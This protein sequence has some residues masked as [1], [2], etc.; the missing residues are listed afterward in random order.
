MLVIVAS[1]AF[2]PTFT[3][4]TVY[5]PSCSGSPAF[6]TKRRFRPGSSEA[7]Q[8]R[9]RALGS[10]RTPG[11]GLVRRRC[12]P[13]AWVR[14]NPQLRDQTYHFPAPIPSSESLCDCTLPCRISRSGG[15]AIPWAAPVALATTRE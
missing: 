14:P 12:R 6:T 10:D 5:E 3:N 13:C 15:A 11:H 7:K 2:L 4:H 9:A 1:L 8:K